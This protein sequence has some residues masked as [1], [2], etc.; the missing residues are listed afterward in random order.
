MITG[1][2]PSSELF[3]NGLDTIQQRLADANRKISSGKSISQPSDAPDQIESLLQ[4]R[5]DR[6]HNTQITSNL[7]LAQTDAQSADN[8]LAS[9]I[10]LMDRALTLGTQGGS[11]ALTAD[12]RTSLAQEVQSLLQQMVSFSQTAVQGRF[13]F[14]GDQESSPVYSYN[15]AAANGVVQ[16]IAPAATKLIEDP[17]GGSFA[18][19]KTAQQIFDTHN[20]DGTVATTNVFAALNNLSAA[21]ASNDT[22]A[23][24]DAID[25]LKQAT[26][27]L[28]N[29]EAFYGTVENRV[30]NAVDFANTY[31][32]QLQTQISQKEDAD[33]PSAA[34]ELTQANTQLQAAFQM[35]AM[36]PTKSLFDYLG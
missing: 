13:I 5:A 23:I 35:R 3:L 18:A 32:T 14:S 25:P 2:D 20:A 15:A 4:L 7:T 17:A 10:K 16:L 24:A 36:M 34:T 27:Y 26:N 31:D 33:I 30:Q 19:I 28:N 9:C 29:M 1:L 22:T 6:Q 11:I 12:N 21:L 8:A